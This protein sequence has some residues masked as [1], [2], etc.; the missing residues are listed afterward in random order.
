M[1]DI[2][3][4]KS[5]LSKNEMI[6]PPISIDSFSSKWN[7]MTSSTNGII[8]NL[9]F[10]LTAGL[11]VARY[12]IKLPTISLESTFTINPAEAMYSA[13][14]VFVLT[15]FHFKYNQRFFDEIIT[16]FKAIN[17]DFDDQT[18]KYFWTRRAAY[19]ILMLLGYMPRVYYCIVIYKYSWPHQSSDQ[20]PKLYSIS[21][22][23]NDD[24][25]N[26]W[27]SLFASL[28]SIPLSL[29]HDLAFID[30]AMLVQSALYYINNQVTAISKEMNIDGSKLD[31]KAVKT[32]RWQ[33][34]LVHRLVDKS[35]SL[36][37]LCTFGL[38]SYYMTFFIF[39][40]YTLAFDDHILPIKISTILQTS[41]ILI[42]LCLII[43]AVVTIY[44]KSQESLPTLYKL[45]FETESFQILN[46]ISLFLYRIG[47]NDVGFSFGGIFMITPDFIST[48]AAVTITVIIAIPSFVVPSS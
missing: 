24:P 41:G 3:I 34:L 18:R 14:K 1:S 2:A 46:E 19:R 38:I 32:L 23:L 7:L 6:Y 16:R 15:L 4:L 13:I 17:I 39:C 20:T 25:L 45:S 48:L 9:L 33:Y 21:A 12:L 29:F 35:S 10:L 44:T 30:L 5:L 31:C 8:G 40:F 47:F 11:M 36:T 28:L 27:T 37:N 22:R 42:V 43:H 26:Y